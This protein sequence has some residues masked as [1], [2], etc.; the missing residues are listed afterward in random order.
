MDDQVKK[1]AYKC[2]YKKKRVDTEHRQLR[3][4]IWLLLFL[5]ENPNNSRSAIRENFLD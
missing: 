1:L 5:M 4:Y 2:K 3:T